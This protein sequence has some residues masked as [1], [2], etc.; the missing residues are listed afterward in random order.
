[1]Y[2]K[3]MFTCNNNNNKRSLFQMN[4]LVRDKMT[5]KKGNISPHAEVLAG[6]CVSIDINW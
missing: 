4:D 2:D 1:M 3:Q 5:D 6:C